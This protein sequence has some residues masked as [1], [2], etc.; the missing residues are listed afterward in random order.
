[1]A[2]EE[3]FLEFMIDTVTIEPYLYMDA[4]KAKVYGPA[5]SFAARISG[6]GVSLRRFDKEEFANIVDVWI[7]AGDVVITVNDRLTLPVANGV[8]VDRTPAIFAI[9]RYTDQ[10]GQHNVKVQCGWMYH[11]QGQ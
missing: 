11:R 10:D 8:W 1:M 3:D 4:K 9:G 2:F 6:K 5:V 7:N